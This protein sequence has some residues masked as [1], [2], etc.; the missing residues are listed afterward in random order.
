VEKFLIPKDP[1]LRWSMLWPRWH[2]EDLPAPIG[3]GQIQHVSYCRNAIYHGL[4]ALR[5]ARHET[6]LA[7]AYHCA[8]AIEPILQF[9]AK[10]VFYNIHPDCT[11]DFEDVRRNLTPSTKAVLVIHYF[12]FPQP[13]RAWQ[14][15]CHAH[16]LKLIEDCAHVLH[17]ELDGQLLGTFGEISVFSLR[18]FFPIDDGGQLV[19]NDHTLSAHIPWERTSAFR[20]L[21][22]VKN[23]I[24]RLGE[25]QESGLG[26]WLSRLV[27]LP[28]RLA[29]SMF[30]DGA[31]P[32]SS[33]ST[34]SRETDFNSASVNMPMTWFSR[35]VMRNSYSPE[36]IRRRR[37]N[38]LRLAEL[39]PK[40][41]AVEC[42]F[43]ALP[44]GV[45]PLVFPFLAKDRSNFHL[46]LRNRGVP[47]VTW[48]GV[49]HDNLPKD[50]YPEAWFLFDRLVMLPIHE[51]IGDREIQLM[52][53]A[54]RIICET[55]MATVV[56]TPRVHTVS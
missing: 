40:S 48:G 22:L 30:V 55:K 32:S 42:V 4:G 7:P 23:A 36:I 50:S 39:M 43:P 51:G 18:K 9:G 20:S 10:V 34:S 1:M 21:Q 15:F 5:I 14:S 41:E 37:D 31:A 26:R 35:F 11:P 8:A 38:Y 16:G 33:I 24:D 2:R 25:N 13:M 29:R 3:T 45:C 53:D 27:S 46:A 6:V 54:V 44:D 19:I 47:A 12:G 56:R 28:G 17:G 49:V 52:A